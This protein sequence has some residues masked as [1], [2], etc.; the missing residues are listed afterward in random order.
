[1]LHSRTVESTIR[2]AQ[3]L[4]LLASI[5]PAFGQELVQV[6][7]TTLSVDGTTFELASHEGEREGVT[8][9]NTYWNESFMGLDVTFMA[10][11][12]PSLY[13]FTP[14]AIMLDFTIAAEAGACPCEPVEASIFFSP[15]GGFTTNVYD[16][17]EGQVVVESI[18]ELEPGIFRVTGSFRG[19][20]G[21][22]V[23]MMDPPNPEQSVS[24]EG[25]FVIERLAQEER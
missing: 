7:S 12:R 25:T 14:G 19:L 23:T 11:S 5:G 17:L 10:Q 1:M 15:E 16:E 22:K 8:V 9:S 6:G 2:I 18:E 20:L 24:V 21:L 3:V 13:S 4:L